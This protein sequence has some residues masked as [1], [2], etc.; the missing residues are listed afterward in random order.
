[1]LNA[2][3]GAGFRLQR[4][5]RVRLLRAVEELGG[6]MDYRDLCQVLLSSCADWTSEEKQVVHKILKSMGVT[7]IERRNWLAKLRQSLMDASSK[8]ARKSGRW[9]ASEPG[10]QGGADEGPAA[11]LGIPPSAFLNCL[12]DS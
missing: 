4:V 10:S 8:V 6:K 11:S 5:N 7:V 12:R 9:F 3:L 1:M 2:L